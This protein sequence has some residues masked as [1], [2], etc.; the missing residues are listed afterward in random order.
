MKD[1]KLE[2]EFEE[3]FK[4]VNTPDNIT[5]DAKKYV[6]TEKRAMP[7]FLKFASVAASFLLV[8]A[9]SLT[10]ILKTDLFKKTDGSTDSDASPPSE[11][12]FRFYSDSELESRN[13]DAYSVSSLDKS[14]IF[15]QNLAV[16]DNAQVSGCK[17]GYKDG[18]LFLVE[19]DSEL[20]YG[21]NRDRT[22]I[23][24]EFTEENLVYSELKDYYGGSKY[25]FNGAEYYLTEQTGENGEPEFKLHI[26]YNGVKY[27]FF[28]SSPDEEAYIKYL[29]LIVK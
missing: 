6:R 28:I 21:L 5:G 20:R 13:A 23:Y 15:L 1:D 26:S 9:L 4:G 24:V 18:K 3:Y 22:K 16:A 25:Y 12:I 10:V 29:Y 17:A 27:Y 8:F 7:K 2:K 19:A 11:S 14:L